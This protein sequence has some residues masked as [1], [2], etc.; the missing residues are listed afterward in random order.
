L[1]LGRALVLAA[2]AASAAAACSVDPLELT[3]KRCPC[4]SGFVCDTATDACVPEGDAGA[5]PAD[6]GDAGDAAARDAG[7]R[8]VVFNLR[9]T[10]ATG[11]GI[12]W[13]WQ[14]LG[15]ADQ[16]DRYE[17]VTGP[18]AEDVRARSSSTKRWD[19]AT[20]P[21][22]GRFG[23]RGSD[24]TQRPFGMWTVTDGHGEGQTVFAQVIAYD[25]AGGTTVTEIPSETTTR[26]R[27]TLVLYENAIADGGAPTP[28]AT[29]VSTQ[30]PFEGAQCLEQKVDCAGAA[31]CAK[32]GGVLGMDG[33]TAS[34]IDVTD[35]DRAYLELAIRGARLPG[36]FSDVTLA[37]GADGC[38]APC[39]MRFSGVS[40]GPAPAEWR[41]VQL[42]LRVLRRNDGT[43]AA[44]NYAELGNRS[45][46]VHGF[47]LSGTWADG[48]TVGLDQARIR[49]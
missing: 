37:I 30:N 39:R 23:G 6:A 10:W 12:R 14:V 22:L 42:P 41:G 16:F 45:Y 34:G 28:G 7:G 19:A 35:F 15:D 5:L 36:Q 33:K 2:T 27:A 49:W 21:E 13:D 3:G 31:S 17:L 11:N 47:L 8:I 32:S 9:S 40:F 18:R 24:P 4:T 48:T 43:G 1:T 46:R 20:N 44:L 29:K 38:G 25:R 26:P